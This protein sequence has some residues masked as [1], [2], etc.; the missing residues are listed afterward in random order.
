M[1]PTTGFVYGRVT[2]SDGFAVADVTVA[3]NGRTATSDASGRYAV[4][5][6]LAQ[7]RRIGT[8]THRNKTFVQTNTAGHNPSTQVIELCREHP[9][10]AQHRPCR[11]DQDG[12]GQRYRQKFRYRP[13]A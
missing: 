7:T 4:E 5:G 9:E 1:T 11:R 3:V 13:A 12:L 10:G 6:F 2:D 8:T